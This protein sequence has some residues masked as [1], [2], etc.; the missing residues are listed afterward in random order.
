MEKSMTVENEMIVCSFCFAETKREAGNL[1]VNVYSLQ[2]RRH[3]KITG[4]K[5]V[6]QEW[7]CDDTCFMEAMKEFVD[8]TPMDSEWD[9]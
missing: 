6:F 4:E 5:T 2:V 1:P 8:S 7:Y 3:S 9:D